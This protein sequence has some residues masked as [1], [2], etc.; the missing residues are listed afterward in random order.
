MASFFKPDLPKEDPS[1][2]AMREREQRR[3]E[4]LA[5]T[6]GMLR[7]IYGEHPTITIAQSGERICVD[8]GGD[9]ARLKQ[10]VARLKDEPVSAG[11]LL[12]GLH[13]LPAAAN[14]LVLYRIDMGE[15]M[16][17]MGPMMDAAGAGAEVPKFPEGV[18]LDTTFWMALDGRQW[19]G[20]LALDPAELKQLIDA[21]R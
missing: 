14:P 17:S 10:S 18:E 16:R 12:A 9:E 15:W 20:G 1:I 6:E 21:G 3:A 11:P 5:A 2:A 13:G 4:A 7:S 8:W 19:C